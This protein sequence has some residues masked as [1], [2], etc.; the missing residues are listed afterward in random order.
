ML[1]W[2]DT[3]FNRGK[4][5]CR[6]LRLV[7]HDSSRR[8]IHS[9][10]G[11][12]SRSGTGHSSR[13]PQEVDMGRELKRSRLGLVFAGA[14]G[15]WLGAR[16]DGLCRRH[17]VGQG[18]G[19]ERRGPC[20]ANGLAQGLL[21]RRRQRRDR[22]GRH[23]EL[24]QRAHRLLLPG[25]PDGR[26]DHPVREHRPSARAEG[27]LRREHGRDRRRLHGARS[28]RRERLDLHVGRI[29]SKRRQDRVYGRRG[30]SD[31]PRAELRDRRRGQLLADGSGGIVQGAVHPARHDAQHRLLRRSDGA[32]RRLRLQRHATRRSTTSMPR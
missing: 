16:G 11:W 23:L 30:R 28:L 6:A 31:Q 2:D 13:S 3:P 21:R 27:D 15:A 24:L 18:Q 19:Q 26:H 25:G 14:V 12:R 20:G 9:R 4:I 10:E 29:P 22:G 32:L 8:T 1:R 7:S 5:V 17:G